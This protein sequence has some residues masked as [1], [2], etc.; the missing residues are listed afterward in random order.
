[1]R[2]ILLALLLTASALQNEARADDADVQL[3]ARCQPPFAVGF[4]IVRVP[5]GPLTAVWYPSRGREARFA[6]SDALAGSVVRDGGPETCGR[7]PLLI[8]SHGL[9]GCG[10]QTVF[11]T[12]QLAR[13]GYVVAAP[14]H[15]DATC[16]VDGSGKLQLRSPER[17]FLQPEKWTAAT[18]ADRR[19]DMS[20]VIDW[21]LAEPGLSKSIDADRVGAVGHSL[22]GYAIL[23]L[24]G[25]WP[26]HTDRRIKAALLLSPYALPFLVQE[27]L[28][29][30]Q[31][32][33][34]Y[35]GA[36]LDLGIT[37]SLHGESGAYAATPG[38][39]AY[40]ELHGGT[41]FEWTNLICLGHPSVLACLRKNANAWLITACRP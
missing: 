17:S 20:R 22:G 9:G 30:V 13:T 32:P 14:D 15:K 4:R 24:I 12:E 41:H 1:M 38:A 33:V 36:Q 10:T 16:R 29:A 39:R 6:Y 23:G 5:G 8:F 2:W 34:M 3:A 31:V 27:R 26:G 18:H 21:A 40:V 28:G 11:L 19:R 25:G 37:P 35:Q 7:F